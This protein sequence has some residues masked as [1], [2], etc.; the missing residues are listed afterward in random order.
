MTVDRHPQVEDPIEPIR[1]NL[2]GPE[3]E[4]DADEFIQL[5]DETETEK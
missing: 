2:M 4:S 5:E 3:N 1:R